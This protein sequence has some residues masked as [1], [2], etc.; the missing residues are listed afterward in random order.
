VKS[1]SQP[2]KISRVSP[3]AS[4]DFCF[5]IRTM[6][7]K[8][9]KRQLVCLSLLWVVFF[10]SLS[11]SFFFLLF[12]L[13]MPAAL[14][15]LQGSNAKRRLAMLLGW[16]KEEQLKNTEANRNFSKDTDKNFE[17]NFQTLLV[18]L[19]CNALKMCVWAR[20]AGRI[21]LY[22]STNNIIFELHLTISNSGDFQVRFSLTLRSYYSGK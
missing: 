20:Y 8:R 7:C 12:W 21:G 15:S 18:N 10:F 6:I 13:D 14:L 3:L 11:L 5:L 4:V 16:D 19:L 1:S 22:G 2:N 17:N 9:F